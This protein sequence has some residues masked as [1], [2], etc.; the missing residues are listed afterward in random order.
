MTLI[1]SIIEARANCQ[2]TLSKIDSKLSQVADQM[3][4]QAD[5]LGDLLPLSYRS[6][7]LPALLGSGR[8]RRGWGLV[9]KVQTGL[10]SI[11]MLTYGLLLPSTY[12]LV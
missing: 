7:R 12:Y 9:F 6:I 4:Q 11:R 2:V 10:Q 1:R 5:I 8:R 3:S